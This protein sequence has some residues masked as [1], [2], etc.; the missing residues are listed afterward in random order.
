MTGQNRIGKRV[1][2]ILVGDRYYSGIILKEDDLLILIKDKFN[3]EVS[4]GKS[5]IISMEV[6]P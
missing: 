2:M 3:Q 4:I 5:A 6:L 1:R